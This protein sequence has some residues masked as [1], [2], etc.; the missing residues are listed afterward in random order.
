MPLKPLLDIYHAM[1]KEIFAAISPPSMP[2]LISDA[3]RAIAFRPVASRP[4]L[5]ERDIY[6]RL[7]MPPRRIYRGAWLGHGNDDDAYYYAQD[8]D[9]RPHVVVVITPMQARQSFHDDIDIAAFTFSSLGI[10]AFS[11]AHTIRSGAPAE[12]Y[13]EAAP[14]SFDGTRG[15]SRFRLE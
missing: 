10:D 15:I 14:A 9:K 5:Y 1:E 8:S 7:L 13:A 11:R 2:L 6:A 12:V 3:E 4:P